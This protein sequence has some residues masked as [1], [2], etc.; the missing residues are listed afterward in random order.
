MIPAHLKLK[1]G[2]TEVDIAE[3]EIPQLIETLKAYQNR[4]ATPTDE[5][6]QRDQPLLI[7]DLGWTPEQAAEASALLQSFQEDWDAPGMEAYDA[8]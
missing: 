5:A 7:Q 6:N 4:P 8:L 3:A 1:I 2:D